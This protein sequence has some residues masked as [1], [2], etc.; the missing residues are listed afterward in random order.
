MRILLATL[1]ASVE[2]L[3]GPA[4]VV[5]AVLDVSGSAYHEVTN[6]CRDIHALPLQRLQEH[7]AELNKPSCVIRGSLTGRAK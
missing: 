5:L 7:I 1:I 2:K 3:S 6:V 4:G